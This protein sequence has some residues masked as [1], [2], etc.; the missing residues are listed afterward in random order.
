MANHSDRRV[1]LAQRKSMLRFAPVLISIQLSLG[2]WCL[3]Q[4]KGSGFTGKWLR[5]DIV[6]QDG[7]HLPRVTWQIT[8]EDKTMTLL[9]LSEQGEVSRTVTFNLDGTDSFSDLRNRPGKRITHRLK[10]KGKEELEVTDILPGSGSSGASGMI[11][12]ETWRLTNKGNTL[13]TVRKIR[14]ADESSPIKIADVLFTFQKVQPSTL[15]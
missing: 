8:F 14:L 4:D 7:S 3:A 2:S 12:S 5:D 1:N 13:K 9:E 15:H 6:N 11:T 10:R